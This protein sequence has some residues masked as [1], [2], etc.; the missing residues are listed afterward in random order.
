[1]I[2][3][4]P[5][6]PPLLVV[7]TGQPPFFPPFPSQECVALSPPALPGVQRGRPQGL[8]TSNTDNGLMRLRIKPWNN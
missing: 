4:E 7:F 5:S 3:T 6:L 1:M 2:E 8:K